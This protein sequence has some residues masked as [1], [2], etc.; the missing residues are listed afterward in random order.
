MFKAPF[1][2]FHEYKQFVVVHWWVCRV[3]DH[4][5]Y[6]HISKKPQNPFFEKV[7]CYK[8]YHFLPLRTWSYSD[9]IYHQKRPKIR[10]IGNCQLNWLKFKSNSDSGIPCAVRLT[11]THISFRP[12]LQTQLILNLFKRAKLIGSKTNPCG[13]LTNQ[14]CPL[15]TLQASHNFLLLWSYHGRIG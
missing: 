3:I 8:W 12:N 4:F 11:H 14:L 13:L 7:Y 15:K 2:A 5:R 10:L 6:E 1:F 9:W